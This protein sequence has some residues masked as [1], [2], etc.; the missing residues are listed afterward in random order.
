MKSYIAESAL[1]IFGL[2]KTGKVVDSVLFRLDPV[3]AANK[4]R[5]TQSGDIVGEIGILIERLKKR[6]Y[7]TFILENEALARKI[8]EKLAV[9][10]EV[11]KPC[12]VIEAFRE[13]LASTAAKL[14]IVKN[15]EEINRFLHQVTLQM[16]R[17]EVTAAAAKRDLYAVQ[18]VRAVDDLDK[19]INLFAGRIRE[20]YGLHFPELDRL[21]DKH[22]T[23]IRLVAKVGDRSNLE[24]ERIEKEGLPK[25]KA[26]EVSDAARKSMGAPADMEDLNCL[27]SF[28]NCALE[29][30]KFRGKA[31]GYVDEVVKE[32]APNMN[33]I[34]GAVL[35]ARLIS[36]AGGLENLAKMPASTIQVLG[37][38]KALFRSL[39]GGAKPPKHGIIFQ[40]TPIHQA[41]RWQR[42]KIAR[43][44]SAKLAIAAR[45]D[46]FGGKFMG[47]A[48]KKN[49]EARI[50]EIREKHRM[51]PQRLK[52]GFRKG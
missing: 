1:G 18:A 42:G 21:I 45:I 48:L 49:L 7:D 30:V 39:R 2:G 33:A 5:K 52:S 22:E 41:P 26:K 11:E 51:P 6:R 27:Q 44:L 28:C 46:A 23:Y 50:A 17:E 9:S 47:D 40:Y 3:E 16:A 38:E 24:L 31:E 32:V 19:T 43:A 25:D 35:S 20:W 15:E 14:K 37:A 36:I 4:L 8:E 12:K 13:K 10:I 29:L 34:V